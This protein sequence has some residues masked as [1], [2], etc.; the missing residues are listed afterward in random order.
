MSKGREGMWAWVLQRV[1]AVLL[2]VGLL[3]HF[4]VT[5]VVVQRPVTFDR[6]RERLVSPA[7]VWFDLILLAL[8]VYHGLNGVHGILVDYGLKGRAQR[9]VAWFLA[10]V[11][12]G[13][14]AVGAWVLQPLARLS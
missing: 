1:T 9:G 2:A 10:V 11:G 8:A 12:V 3:V 6:V 14:F 4:V 7:W 13:T 5:H